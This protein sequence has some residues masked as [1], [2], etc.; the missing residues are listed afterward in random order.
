[1]IYTRRFYSRKNRKELEEK[2]HPNRIVL[3]YDFI[4]E[5]NKR[6]FGLKYYRDTKKLRRKHKFDE[7]K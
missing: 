5:K 4:D 2:L 7:Q 6:V 1:M 3:K